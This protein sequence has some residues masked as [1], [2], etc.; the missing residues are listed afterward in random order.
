MLRSKIDL[1]YPGAWLRT[2]GGPI[3]GLYC[4]WEVS[5][6]PSPL[7]LLIMAE[8]V[9]DFAA[10]APTA[11]TGILTAQ[12]PATYRP[13]TIISRYET[14]PFPIKGILL[15]CCSAGTPV[16]CYCWWWLGEDEDDEE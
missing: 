16:F 10:L 8:E 3:D 5:G 6:G 14:L 7:A 4:C 13:T 15:R 12:S 2:G 9:A 11:G 1:W